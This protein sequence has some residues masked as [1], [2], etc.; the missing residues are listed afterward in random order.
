[1]TTL[2]PGSNASIRLGNSINGCGAEGIKFSFT[3]NPPY[4]QY[5]TYHYA[6]V[7]EDPGHPLLE[8]PGL[9]VNFY[10]QSNNIIPSISDT[11]YSGD[12]QYAFITANNPN[13]PGPVLYKRW[14]GVTVDLT[15]YAGQTLTVEFNNFD[16]AFCGHFGYTYLDVSCYGSLIANVWPGDCD[17]D[18]NANNV[19][20][21]SLGIAYGATG[22][23]RP[24]ASNNWT[25]HSP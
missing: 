8:Q 5:F 12:P 16:C 17:Y 24:G 25:A 21:I 14:S 23:T 13:Y 7:F 1:M 9:A 6:S 15:A 19:D 3:V 4:N 11:I 20:L 18:L 10:D 2:A 22:A